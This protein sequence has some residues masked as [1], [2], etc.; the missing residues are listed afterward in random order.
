MV[1]VTTEQVMGIEDSSAGLA[2]IMEWAVIFEP[3]SVDFQ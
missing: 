3:Q 2:V 1:F